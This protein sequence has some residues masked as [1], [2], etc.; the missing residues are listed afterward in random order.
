MFILW[1]TSPDIDTQLIL[2]SSNLNLGHLF[3]YVVWNAKLKN[4]ALTVKISISKT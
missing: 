2:K 1:N 4:I 3:Q